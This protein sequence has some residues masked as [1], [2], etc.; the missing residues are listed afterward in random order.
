MNQRSINILLYLVMAYILLAGSWW[1]YLLQT[2]TDA[3]WSAQQAEI[4]AKHPQLSPNERQKLISFQ[5]AQSHYYRQ[6]MMIMGEGLVFLSLL[7]L[8]VYKIV[9]S[10]RKQWALAQQQQN[11]LLSITHELKSPIASVQ[12]VLETLQKH[13]LSP[14][15]IQRLSKNALQ[16]NQRLHKLVQDLLLAARVEGGHQYTFECLDLQQLLQEVIQWVQPRFPNEIHFIHDDQLDCMPQGDRSMLQSAF[17]NLLDNALKY[18]GQSPF[19]KVE[20][21][22]KKDHF[23]I[24]FKDQGPGIPKTERQAIFQKFY[25]IGDER[26]RKS[27]G[28]GLGLYILQ[29]V[30]AAHHGQIQIRDNQPQGSI[31]SI[32]LPIK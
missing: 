30:I 8:G 27:K 3:V 18:A 20:L 12:L 32:K 19:L 16:D 2:K 4:K 5:A 15:Q 26:T 9:Q 21:R 6:R 23:L 17:H 11:F 14:T 22:Q 7:L 31:F 28:T 25:R 29:K 1:A 13:Q 10:Q 24:E